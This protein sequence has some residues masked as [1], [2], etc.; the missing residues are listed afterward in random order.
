MIHDKQFDC[1]RTAKFIK[2]LLE[3]LLKNFCIDIWAFSGST[4]V[5]FSTMKL[6]L[7]ED[8]QSLTTALR[9]V[10][11]GSQKFFTTPLVQMIGLQTLI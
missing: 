2:N 1:V 7:N 9:T 11:I 6:A 8:T 5:L 10:K 4:N 3:D